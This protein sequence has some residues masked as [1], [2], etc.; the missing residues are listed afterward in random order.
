M[1]QQYN[2]ILLALEYCERI[3]IDRE[4]CP[5]LV[6][7][8]YKSGQYDTFSFKINTSVLFGSI[9]TKKNP[10]AHKHIPRAREG[11]LSGRTLVVGL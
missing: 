2:R 8:V 7:M 6:W 10:Y 4:G 1:Q 5:G 3:L 9:Y 11:I